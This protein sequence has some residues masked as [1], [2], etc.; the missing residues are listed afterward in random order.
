[1]IYDAHHL[2]ASYDGHRI[3]LRGT[4]GDQGDLRGTSGDLRGTSGDLRGTGDDLRGA[5]G[6]QRDLRGGNIGRQSRRPCNLKT[7][8]AILRPRGTAIRDYHIHGVA[9]G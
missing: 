9:E 5:S 3:C 4:N 6:D 2:R 8:N 1:M 7:S